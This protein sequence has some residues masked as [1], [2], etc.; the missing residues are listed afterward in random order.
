MELHN[1]AQC[2]PRKQPNIPLAGNIFYLTLSFPLKV[3][4]D[5]SGFNA[6]YLKVLLGLPMLDLG[7]TCLVYLE[8]LILLSKGKKTA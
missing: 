6:L 5:L 2:T 4:Y 7:T 1:A 3:E 8:N